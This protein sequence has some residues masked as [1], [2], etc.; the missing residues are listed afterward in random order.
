MQ[1]RLCDGQ[2][3]GDEEREREIEREAA[4]DV[5]LPGARVRPFGWNCVNCLL[6]T[7]RIAI[8]TVHD[9]RSRLGI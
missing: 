2:L 3:V 1:T 4:E 6:F 9:V 5:I 8:V 7:I